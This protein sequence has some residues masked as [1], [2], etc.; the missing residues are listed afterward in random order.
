LDAC[1]RS[2]SGSADQRAPY[3]LVDWSTSR[4]IVFRVVTSR[5]VSASF[6][7]LLLLLPLLPLLA[8][9]ALPAPMPM[10][11]RAS[12]TASSCHACT[13]CTSF[14]QCSLSILRLCAPS[15]PMRAR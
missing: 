2:S 6:F 5:S 10:S 12:A 9:L 11:A 15:A 1:E 13:C 14:S 4:R 8:A 7:E 3:A